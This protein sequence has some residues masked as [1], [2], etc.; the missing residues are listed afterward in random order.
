MQVNAQVF[1]P[2]SPGLV[3]D[4]LTDPGFQE[5]VCQATGA[6]EYDVQIE[7]A[8]GE[9]TITTRRALPTDQVPDYAR[10]FIG[11]T[12]EVLRVD[13]WDAPDTDGNRDGTVTLEIKGA[14][15]R[16][17][18]SLALRV[19]N[20]GGTKQLIAGDLRASIPL[21]GG[22]MERAAEPALMSAIRKEEEVG[23]QQLGG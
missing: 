2:A 23:L 20:T 15:I 14:P 8:A 17:N 13:H 6:L 16:L 5:R 3:F 19:D 11:S 21:L 22:K 9:A 7:Q 4:M 12:L 1:Y 10:S 18:G